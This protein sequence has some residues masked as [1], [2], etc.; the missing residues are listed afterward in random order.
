MGKYKRNVYILMCWK[1]VE[2]F[3]DL[4]MYDKNEGIHTAYIMVI[5]MEER[6]CKLVYEAVG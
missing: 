6:K 4:K 1:C 5:E 3:L 2:R